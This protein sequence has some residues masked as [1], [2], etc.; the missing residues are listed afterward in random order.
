MILL[1]V[2]SW[3]ELCCYCLLVNYSC[4]SE[5]YSGIDY[6]PTININEIII[7]TFNLIFVKNT[8]CLFQIRLNILNFNLVNCWIS[9][10]IKI[11]FQILAYS[12]DPINYN[13][14]GC[15]F[16]EYFVNFHNFLFIFFHFCLSH[17][18]IVIILI[19]FIILLI[20][21][22]FSSI[23]SEAK[24]RFLILIKLAIIIHIQLV[25]CFSVSLN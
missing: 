8:R 25:R 17:S 24:L 18:Y 2:F 9:L 12:L 3:I 23:S 6:K 14:V 1:L 5:S 22:L 7:H 4:S 19:I 10:K 20:F 15:F 16:I 21:S 11:R 13:R